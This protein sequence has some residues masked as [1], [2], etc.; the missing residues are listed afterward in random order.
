MANDE[1]NLPDGAVVTNVLTVV[2]YLDPSTG[3]LY[4]ADFSRDSSGSEID[5]GKLLELCS[6]AKM[7]YEA[8]IIADL[9]MGY[10]Q[11]LEDD[12]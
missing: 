12:E 2:E 9:V 6:F 7:M 3:E 5:H 10:V 8:P 11:S 4:K 1:Y